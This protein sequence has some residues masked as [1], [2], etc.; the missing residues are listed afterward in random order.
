M[1][2]ANGGG[3]DQGLLLSGNMRRNSGMKIAIFKHQ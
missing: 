3:S 2:F 1:L